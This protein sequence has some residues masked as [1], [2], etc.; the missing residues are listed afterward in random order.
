[1]DR[2]I[3]VAFT[4]FDR[5]ESE[6]MRNTME[7][8]Q[9]FAAYRCSPGS[10]IRQFLCADTGRCCTGTL[11]LMNNVFDASIHHIKDSGK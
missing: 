7:H 2:A 3:N 8:K 1:M 11:S 4:V 9:L 5:Y 10:S 6:A